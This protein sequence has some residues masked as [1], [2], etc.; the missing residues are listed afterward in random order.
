MPLNSLGFSATACWTSTQRAQPAKARTKCI[1]GFVP[2]LLPRTAL[3]ST[4]TCSSTNPGKAAVAQAVKAA[5]EGDRIDPSQHVAQG[6][7]R[8]NP[9]GQV[10]KLPQPGFLLL[11]KVRHVGGVGWTV[12]VSGAHPA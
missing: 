12:K 6:I 11:G 9:V 8:W 7:V 3:P 10:Q 2:S 4:H 5:L 1:A